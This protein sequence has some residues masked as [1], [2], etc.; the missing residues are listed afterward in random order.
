M[1]SIMKIGLKVYTAKLRDN[2]QDNSGQDTI[3][4]RRQYLQFK[5]VKERQFTYQKKPLIVYSFSQKILKDKLKLKKKQENNSNEDETMKLR[6]KILKKLSPEEQ[7]KVKRGFGPQMRLLSFYESQIQRKITEQ[8]SNDIGIDT[9]WD[10][11]SGTGEL[12]GESQ[13]DFMDKLNIQK[14]DHL[15]NTVRNTNIENISGVRKCKET[16]RLKHNSTSIIRCWTVA[17]DHCLVRLTIKDRKRGLIP[18]IH[19]ISIEITHQQKAMDS[20][21]NIN[22]STELDYSLPELELELNFEY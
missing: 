9:S 4:E 2:N 10:F 14:F 16:T 18:V 1:D 15:T 8:N 17:M 21:S 11:G 13:E 20:S 22:K 7:Q 5:P 19:K 3:V 12:Q 6:M